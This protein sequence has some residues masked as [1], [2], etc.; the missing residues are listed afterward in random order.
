MIAQAIRTA[1]YPLVRRSERTQDLLI[2]SSFGLW[3]A[4]LGLAPVLAFHLLMK[5]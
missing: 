3:A 5:S 4:L 2:V 1:I